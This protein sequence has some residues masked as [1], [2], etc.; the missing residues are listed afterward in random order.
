M[1]N[2]AFQ[3][4]LH[5]HA[6]R[7]I[8]LQHVAWKPTFLTHVTLPHL[9]FGGYALVHSLLCFVHKGNPFLPPTLL[10]SFSLS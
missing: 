5:I 9:A 1:K 8:C 10:S 2:S 6:V 3:E 4:G 7:T